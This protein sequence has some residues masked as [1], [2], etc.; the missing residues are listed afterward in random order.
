LIYIFL[1]SSQLILLSTVPK[2]LNLFVIKKGVPSSSCE[3]FI[4]LYGS[5]FL[6]FFL[7]IQ[8]SLPYKK[9]IER[10]S[11]LYTFFLE[12]FW[13]KVGLKVLFKIPSI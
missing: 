11:A 1:V 8:I 9:Y 7:S 2:F 5:N 13:S 12:S 3:K 4:S 10:A 6:L